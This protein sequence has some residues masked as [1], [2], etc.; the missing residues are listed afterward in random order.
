MKINLK[1]DTK[2]NAALRAINGRSSSFCYTDAYQI[3]ALAT[4]ADA[5]L[6]ERG[7]YKKHANGSKLEARM[8]GPTAN[9]YKYSANATAVT[10]IRTSGAWF[11]TDVEMETVY[12]RSKEWFALTV[13]PDAGADIIARAMNNITITQEAIR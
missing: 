2:I 4:R 7:V 13:Q 8:A 11:M 6:A 1:N 3:R 5:L 10:L 12:P 9:R